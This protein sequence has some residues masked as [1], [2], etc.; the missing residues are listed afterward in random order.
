MNDYIQLS[1]FD[2]P[3][4]KPIHGLFT[5]EELLSIETKHG[6]SPAAKFELYRFRTICSDYSK[7]KKIFY[8]KAVCEYQGHSLPDR[9]RP[10]WH[11]EQSGTKVRFQFKGY[12][13][14]ITTTDRLCRQTYF[15]SEKECY[16]SEDDIK[17]LIRDYSRDLDNPLYADLRFRDRLMLEELETIR[18][19]KKFSELVKLHNVQISEYFAEMRR[20]KQEEIEKSMR[21]CELNVA[22]QSRT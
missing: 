14:Y 9:Y 12:D 2:D 11:C 5:H 21:G 1:F 19:K 6:P 17:W 15:E 13:D 8:D 18:D 20:K 10:L 22:E 3:Q 7:F 16:I 4:I